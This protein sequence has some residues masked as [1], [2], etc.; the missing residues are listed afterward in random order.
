MS[1]KK[2]AA[3]RLRSTAEFARHVGLARST[4]SRVLN[5]QPGLRPRTIERVQR[6]LAE[7]GFT[8]NAHALALRGKRT[9]TVGL[10]VENLLTPPAVAKLAALQRH[11]RARRHTSL[12]EVFEPGR[13]QELIRQFLSLRVDAV[14]FIGH[15]PPEEVAA[16][17]AELTAHDTPHAVIDQVG[18]RG[19]HTV[20]LDRAHGME[21][22]VTRLL[23]L[24]HRDFGLLA[25]S[26]APTSRHDR[27]HGIV[28]A[29]AAHGLDPAACV[30]SLDHLHARALPPHQAR[31]S[32][33]AHGRT[34]A[35]AFASLP[36]PPTACLALNDEI[37][38]GALRGF[39]DAGLAVPR[40]VSVTGFNNQDLCDMTAPTLTS[41]DQRIDATAETA[42][43]L[44]FAQIAGP[45]P[46]K[47]LLRL[48]APDFIE[49]E[50]IGPARKS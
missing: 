39:A 10:C 25:L 36:R 29:L 23:N 24:G 3:L 21:C 32:D 11:L 16:R 46:T 45:T 34:L 17:I 42:A 30:R 22:V 9:A 18:V 5:G 26:T 13:S 7:T 27:M 31:G 14:V 1:G 40:D 35:H 28:A 8:A 33:F 38:A 43:E 50:S 12:I 6:A 48:I 41:V 47:P 2:T 37:A 49:R 44:I 15:F 4:V 19:A 20:T